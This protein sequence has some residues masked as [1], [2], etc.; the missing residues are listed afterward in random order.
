[1][2]QILTHQKLIYSKI[3]V[4]ILLQV[5]DVFA[6]NLEPMLYKCRHGSSPVVTNRGD[7][8]HQLFPSV[9]QLNSM[10]VN[11]TPSPWI[12]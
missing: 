4:H 3:V 9:G 5:K 6:N 10:C 7:V 8:I 1:M 12:E 11:H 2:F